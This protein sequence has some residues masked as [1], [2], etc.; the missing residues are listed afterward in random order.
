MRQCPVA[1]VGERQPAAR[2][3]DRGA[4]GEER[5]DDQQQQGEYTITL[6]VPV[7]LSSRFL[8]V[9]AADVL[10]GSLEKLIMPGL[11]ERGLAHYSSAVHA[12]HR[13]RVN[14]DLIGGPP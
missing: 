13:Q 10:V 5:E 4:V 2:A 12:V 8:G 9:A 14:R 3:L 7:R 1:R 11:L 6:S